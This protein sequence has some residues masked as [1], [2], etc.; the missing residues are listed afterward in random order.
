MPNI[1][2][3]GSHHIVSSDMYLDQIHTGTG[4]HFQSALVL[5]CLRV[6][7]FVFKLRS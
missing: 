7:Y 1:A 3:Y 6:S 5:S 2:R 4:L